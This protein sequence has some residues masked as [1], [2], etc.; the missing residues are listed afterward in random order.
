[1][2]VVCRQFSQFSAA[3]KLTL[4]GAEGVLGAVKKERNE[5]ESTDIE[6]GVGF[7]RKSFR[8]CLANW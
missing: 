3:G 1:M 7:F 2:Y 6:Q 4:K 8:F 5:I